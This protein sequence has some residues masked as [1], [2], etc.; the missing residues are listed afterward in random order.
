MQVIVL[1]V[2]LIFEMQTE[3]YQG[4]LPIHEM[5]F[6]DISLIS[7]IILNQIPWFPNNTL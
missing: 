3:Q 1:L 6:P 5:K 2:R 7:L 4:S